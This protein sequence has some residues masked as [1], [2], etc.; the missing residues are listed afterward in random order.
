MYSYKS[1]VH[2]A[3]RRF[4]LDWQI[5][6]LLLEDDLFLINPSQLE[7]M[8]LGNFFGWVFFFQV[9]IIGNSLI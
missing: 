7:L 8:H 5:Y 3:T 1:F 2:I 6:L 9:E 4:I